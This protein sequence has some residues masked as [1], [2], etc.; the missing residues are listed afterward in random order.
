MDHDRT[1][2]ERNTKKE[3]SNKKISLIKELNEIF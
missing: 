1:E 3:T 2:E